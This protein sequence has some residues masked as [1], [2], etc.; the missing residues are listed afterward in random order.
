MHPGSFLRRTL[1]PPGSS[2]SLSQGPPSAVSG[3]SP[4][5]WDRPSALSR[6]PGRVTQL[7]RRMCSKRRFKL[8]RVSPA[9]TAD[10]Q[11]APRS[12]PQKGNPLCG[13]SS[14]SNSGSGCGYALCAG[15]LGAI[16][17]AMAAATRGAAAAVCGA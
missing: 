15:V 9:K 11:D 4:G 5:P 1:S 16:L 14:G 13:R 12:L 6:G 3:L 2:L 7:L 17:V 8:D 10:G